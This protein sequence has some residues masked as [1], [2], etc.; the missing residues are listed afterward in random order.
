MRNWLKFTPSAPS[1][2]QLPY[3]ICR[4]GLLQSM[5]RPQRI[6]VGLDQ[7]QSLQEGIRGAERLMRTLHFSTTFTWDAFLCPL[8]PPWGNWL[9]NFPL[10]SQ[11]ASLLLWVEDV[12]S[13][14]HLTVLWGDVPVIYSFPSNH[15]ETFSTSHTAG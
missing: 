10:Q 6:S 2:I 11:S 14:S 5:K 13:K 15:C 7:A 4:Q 1:S 12:E 3:G 8:E 9:P